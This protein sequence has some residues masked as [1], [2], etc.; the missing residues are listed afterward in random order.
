ML[1]VHHPG[2]PKCAEVVD[3]YR[4]LLAD[5]TSVRAVD[6]AAIADALAGHVEAAADV[7]WLQDF[8]DRYV[9]LNLSQDLVGLHADQ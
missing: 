4:A 5:P 3:G 2:D 6:I 7:Q 9:N 1:V 8:R